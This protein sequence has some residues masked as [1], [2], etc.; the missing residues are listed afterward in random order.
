M[1]LFRYQATQPAEGPGGSLGVETPRGRRLARPH[2]RHV[3]N[4]PDRHIDGSR[5]AGRVPRLR[6][7]HPV[8]RV[9]VPP[10]KGAGIL[11][12]DWQDRQF[13]EAVGTDRGDGGAVEVGFFNRRFMMISKI[14]AALTKTWLAGSAIRSCLSHHRKTCVSSAKFTLPRCRT[15]PRWRGVEIGGGAADAH[16]IGRLATLT[17]MQRDEMRHGS[18]RC[19][20]D[21]IG[22]ARILVNLVK[23]CRSSRTP[24]PCGTG[25]GIRVW[26]VVQPGRQH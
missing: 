3:R 5:G 6:H 14:D 15:E 21:L 22:A 23:S 8:E 17:V 20:A 4:G 24:S 11:R 9:A 25:Q 1:S 26:S 13:M 2:L 18:A 12:V 7:Q 16:G 19:Q 10:G